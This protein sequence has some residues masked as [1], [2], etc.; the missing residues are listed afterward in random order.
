ML[1]TVTPPYEPASLHP[2]MPPPPL[3]PKPGKDN[4]KLQRLLKKAAKK[5][6][7]LSA[8]QT[9]SFRSSLSPVS[10][11]SPDLE[12]SERSSP[13]KPTEMATHL[14]IN[15]P[16][17]FS[18]RPVIHHVSSPF[19]KGKPFTFTVAEQK[20]LSEHLRVT[21]SPAPSPLQ[22]P[23]TAEPSWPLR[24]QPQ[25]DA[26]AQRSPSSAVLFSPEPPVHLIPV[27]EPPAVVAHIAETHTSMYS[28][29]AAS[30]LLQQSPK[31][32]SSEDR[33]PP[34]HPQ[35]HQEHPPPGQIPGAYFSSQARPITP[36]F[37][38]AP[39][40]EPPTRTTVAILHVPRQ[41]IVVTSPAP[42]VSRPVMPGSDGGPEPHKEA[43]RHA[44]PN[45]SQ[46]H[47]MPETAMPAPSTAITHVLSPEARREQSLPPPVTFQG[48][49]PKP[50]PA[51]P[52][53][54]KLSGWSRLKKHLI[55]DSEEPQFP[56]PEPQ[57][58]KSEEEGAERTQGSQVDTGQDKRITKSRAIKMWDAIVYQ[59]MTSKAKKQQRDERE[60]RRD[61]TFPF[62]RRLP[63]LLHRP[64]FD[65]R[66]LKELASKPMTKITTL[67]EVRRIQ[68]KTPE[69][70]PLR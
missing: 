29:Q 16:P 11:A 5:K 57:P 34:L 41:Q 60:I 51:L 49:L 8:Q 67:F 64:R 70:S 30:P 10:E 58:T 32:P 17:R 21:S 52:P 45:G 42:Q 38:P 3:P 4:L 13:L 19:P 7:T 33:P 18:I 59:M 12:R 31:Y 20:S 65:A 37:E 53:R 54:N 47:I 26:D 44:T 14:T 25:S 24:G 68:C 39:A 62:R 61:G 43:Q 23:S 9:T 1:I 36:K 2:Q 46:K 22:R 55:I 63:L 27:V 50:K 56:V 6:A 40:P 28:M 66:K 69:E 35:V 48:T 15:L